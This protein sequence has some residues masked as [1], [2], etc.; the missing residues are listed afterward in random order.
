MQLSQLKMCELSVSR[1]H[2]RFQQKQKF[3]IASQMFAKKTLKERFGTEGIATSDSCKRH[4]ASHYAFLMHF[5]LCLFI[6]LTH[7]FYCL[8]LI[9]S[10]SPEHENCTKFHQNR[11]KTVDIYLLVMTNLY[12]TTWTNRIKYF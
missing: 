11:G 9:S 1:A 7:S 3:P 12:F 5:R 10:H 6:S 4:G 2:K 8:S